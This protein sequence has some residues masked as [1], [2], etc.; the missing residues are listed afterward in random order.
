MSLTSKKIL[1]RRF[2]GRDRLNAVQH[3][4]DRSG[5]KYVKFYLKRTLRTRLDHCLDGWCLLDKE[6]AKLRALTVSVR[7]LR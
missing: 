7:Q 6:T 1:S 4:S 3:L 2:Y 5:P